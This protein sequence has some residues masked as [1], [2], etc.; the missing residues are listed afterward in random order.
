[1]R[2]AITALLCL[3]LSA[4]EDLP[5]R[6]SM[7][8]YRKGGKGLIA[9]TPNHPLWTDGL[10]KAR[11]ARIPAPIDANQ[12]EGWGYPAG[13]T[14]WKDFSL[15]ARRL[16]TRVLRRTAHGWTYGSYVWRADQRE[17]D[18]APESGRKDL[19]RLAGGQRVDAPAVAD[20]RRC[21]ENGG[22][23]VLGFDALQL[24]GPQL[25][26][27]QIRGLLAHLPATAPRITGRTPAET[28]A[29]GYFQGNCGNCHRPEGP[30]K[31]LGLTL[32]QP[33]SSQTSPVA[34]TT[35]N[36][37]A[38]VPFPGATFRI[39]AGHPAASALL[40]RM[41]RRGDALQMPPL[42]TVLLDPD[43]LARVRAW[44]AGLR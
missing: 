21:H 1:M 34:A 44:A 35:V 36:Q 12:P 3:G 25:Q 24:A 41:E 40:K 31:A 15:G 33:L 39:A 18:L 27:L 26:K 10:G 11:W 4:A 14:F 30:L 22:S 17:A 29:L 7:T 37:R 32:R 23:P 28:S 8:G 9:F 2:H 20:C 38:L 6:L 16:E 13:T 42:G 19:A 43:G 5:A